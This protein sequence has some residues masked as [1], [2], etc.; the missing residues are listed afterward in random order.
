MILVDA[1]IHFH[2]CYKMNDFFDSAKS[3]FLNQAKK[4]INQSNENVLCLTESHGVNIFNDLF[5][6]AESKKKIGNWDINIT[7]NENTILISNSKFKIYVIAGRQIV[8][9]EKLEVLA[10]GLNSDIED[11]LAIDEVIKYVIDSESIPV[12]PWGFGKWLSS[13]KKIVEKI[14]LQKR[15][16]PIFL[17]DNGNRPVFFGKSRLFDIAYN[18][19]IINLPGSDPLPFSNEVQKPGSFGFIIDDVLNEDKPFDSIYEKLVN[20]KIQ[21]ETYGKLESP[22][23]F[24]KNQIAMQI[25]KR[26]RN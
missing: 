12:I 23:I 6:I 17:G 15:N 9:K 1:H 4:M 18:N 16:H 22:F 14:I 25:V 3:N 13:R 7:G 2:D 8:T 11:G 20:T 24:L 21:Y 10:L 26:N 5:I 19:G